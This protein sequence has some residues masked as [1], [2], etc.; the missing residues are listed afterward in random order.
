MSTDWQL[1]LAYVSYVDGNDVATVKIP[2]LSGQ[3]GIYVQPSDNAGWTAPTAGDQVFV[4]VN[5][6]ASE[7][8][9]LT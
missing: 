1:H 6:D 4:A 2:A 3:S 8:R 9:W 7:V 5:H